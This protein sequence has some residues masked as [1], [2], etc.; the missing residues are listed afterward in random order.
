MDGDDE[1]ECSNSEGSAARRRSRQ[2]RSFT[3]DT[4]PA[5]ECGSSIGSC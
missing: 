2:T 4:P 1:E 5:C 3:P